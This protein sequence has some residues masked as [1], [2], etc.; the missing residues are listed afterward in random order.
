MVE[1]WVRRRLGEKEAHHYVPDV[2]NTVMERLEED[3]LRLSA[4]L[5][6]H[7]RVV[8]VTGAGCS[9][10]SG[11]PDYRSPRGSYSRGHK[12]TTFQKFAES[13]ENRQRY[14]ARGL[15]GWPLMAAVMPNRCHDSLAAL[16]KMGLLHRLITQNVDNLHARA[17]STDVIELHG[18]MNTVVCLGCRRLSDRAAFQQRMEELNEE[19][20]ADVIAGK[21][22]MV[23]AK[24]DADVDF[25][26]VDYSNITVPHCQECGEE[27]GVIKPNVVFFGE[28]L[29]PG[30]KR[31]ATSVVTEEA[32]ALLVIGSS[33][34]VPSA[35]RLV[36]AAEQQGLPLAVVNVGPTKVDG[37]EG[38]LRIHQEAGSALEKC[39][40]R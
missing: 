1:E 15:F 5:Q 40:R 35:H 39:L 22:R 31:K 6:E 11:T 30:V 7:K 38:V 37:K 33:L 32:S 17:G 8:A 14:W 12:P 26:M 28:N 3:S 24:A 4:F 21:L 27:R 18:S 13:H 10:A 23:D 36:K 34:E 16:Q 29:D 19:Y 25:G 20:V 2:D 9:T